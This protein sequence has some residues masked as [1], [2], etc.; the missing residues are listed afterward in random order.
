MSG[1][2]LLKEKGAHVCYHDPYVPA[3]QLE[4]LEMASAANLDDALADADCVVI[5]ADHSTY[6]WPAIHRQARLM[7]DTRATQLQLQSV[8]A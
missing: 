4:G 3:F 1:R 6:D 5:A 2:L 7:V 8:T